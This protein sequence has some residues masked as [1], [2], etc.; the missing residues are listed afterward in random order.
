MGWRHLLAKVDL[1][2]LHTCLHCAQSAFT[3]PF[4]PRK[5]LRRW[6]WT[7]SLAARTINLFLTT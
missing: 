4:V 3:R 7:S 6:Y 5:G 2:H 1:N